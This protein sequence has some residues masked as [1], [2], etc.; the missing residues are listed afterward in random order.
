VSTTPPSDRTRVRRLP[1]LGVYERASID[2]ILDEALICHVAYI[3]AEGSPRL[4][5]TIHVRVGDTLYFHGS[6][7]SQTLRALRGGAKVAVAA[8]ILD[9]IRF[10]R[11][12]FEHS[13]NYRS[14]IVYGTTQPVTDPAELQIVARAITDHVAPGRGA[15]ARMPNETELKQTSFLSVALDECSAKISTGQATDPDEDYSLDVWAGILPLGISLGTPE[16]DPLL[17][18]GV[19]VPGY[20]SE[21]SRRAQ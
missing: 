13:M 6:S 20:I 1:E 12:M 15:E 3:D 4:I 21:Y 10:A 7:A 11:S 2:A 5:P 8:T 17:K 16:P 18:A 9:G 14:V 19:Q